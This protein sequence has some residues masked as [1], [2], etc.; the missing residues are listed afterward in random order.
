MECED[1]DASMARD[2]AKAKLTKLSEEFKKLEA[3]H[4]EL[5]EDHSILKEDLGELEERHSE[6]LEQ[7]KES[8]ASVDRAVKSKVIAKEKYQH[9]QGQYKKMRLQLKG[10]KAKVANYLH[11]LSFT[12]RIR[13]SAWADGLHL[14]FET[15]KAWW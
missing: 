7:L 9:F 10:A 11:I 13:D 6:T 14:G 3:E 2:Q 5:Q 1:S 12:S 4:T 8:Q 15:F